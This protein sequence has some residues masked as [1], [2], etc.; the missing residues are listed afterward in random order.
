MNPENYKYEPSTPK[1][2]QEEVPKE[3]LA[4]QET[5]Y[6]IDQVEHDLVSRYQPKYLAK[7]GEHIVYE[8]PEHP[9][10]VIKVSTGP[11]KKVIDWNVAHGQPIDSLPAELELG[12]REYLKEETV[13][14]QLLKRYFGAEHVPSQKE[15][16]IK[17]PIT[18]EILNAFYE[19]SPPA[20]TNEVW[21]IVMIQKRIEAVSDPERLAIVAGYAE[22]NEVSEELYNQVTQHLVFGKNP[23][24]IIEIDKFLQVQFPDEL[25]DLL[26]KS[27]GDEN[28]RES[29]RELLERIIT[30]T[31]E[32]G[33]IF[34][35]VGQDNIVIFQRDGK[36]TYSLV[37]TRYPGENKMVEKA[38]IALLKLSVGSEI[39]EH[40]KNVLLNIFNYV[41][42]V[43]GLAELMGSQKR[44]NI[45]PDGMTQ[46]Q[47]D[48]LKIFR[49]H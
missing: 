5:S 37:D 23:E 35:L 49:N 2:D 32:T 20:T 14:Y 19:G 1:V 13:R 33:E 40:E 11:L 28:L 29:L 18:Q 21:G 16:L 15:F 39:D 10:M 34:D 3:T 47:I 22:N 48:F 24:E 42:T 30:Y 38:K 31:E 8:V 36:W 45:V 12:A 26:E 27:N 17:V 6:E 43:N 9:D 4:E 41:R 44:I 7:G 25:K 46:E